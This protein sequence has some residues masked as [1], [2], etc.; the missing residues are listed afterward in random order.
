LGKPPKVVSQQRYWRARTLQVAAVLVAVPSLYFG[1]TGAG[2]LTLRVYN[3]AIALLHE[4][5]DGFFT[6][7]L[8]VIAGLVGIALSLSAWR[9]ARIMLYPGAEDLLKV[10]GRAPIVF[11]R[12]FRDDALH[13]EEEKTDKLS[14]ALSRENPKILE[15]MHRLDAMLMRFF[16]SG[17]ASEWE[18][19]GRRV[20]RIPFEPIVHKQLRVFGPLIAIGRPGEKRPVLGASRKYVSDD[21]WRTQVMT[22]LEQARMI[23]VIAGYTDG[24]QWELQQ[25][26]RKGYTR[27]VLVLLPP[28]RRRLPWRK[29]A[30]SLATRARLYDELNRRKRWRNMCEAIVPEA[31]RAHLRRRRV[32]NIVG[33]YF[34]RTG[35][36]VV[37]SCRKHTRNNYRFALRAA[38]HGMFCHSWEESTPSGELPAD[39]SSLPAPAGPGP[40]TGLARTT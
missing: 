13:F 20:E 40:S 17:S 27:K 28:S 30:V 6:W 8:P 37:L 18:K 10:D 14:H 24:I 21:D 33:F 26:A 12:S 34:A 32:E 3:F 19:P 23:V 29:I 35:M 11:L 15:W 9:L 25:I 38:I 31:D 16:L 22:W 4:V 36:P 2:Q 7:L 5:S 1:V 39:L